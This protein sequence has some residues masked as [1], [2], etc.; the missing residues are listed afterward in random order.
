MSLIK[1]KKKISA[2]KIGNLKKFKYIFGREL[3]YLS[4]LKIK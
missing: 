1:N 4:L 2:E 3:L